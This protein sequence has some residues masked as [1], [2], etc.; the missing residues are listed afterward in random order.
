ML[1][2][3]PTPTGPKISLLWQVTASRKICWLNKKMKLVE[4]VVQHRVAKNVSLFIVAITSST[5]NQLS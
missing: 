1:V 4:K 2:K 3:R 5:A